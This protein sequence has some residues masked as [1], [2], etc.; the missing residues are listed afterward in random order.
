MIVG[1][2]SSNI[3]KHDRVP[4]SPLRRFVVYVSD[5]VKQFEEE[6]LLT[7]LGIFHC[8]GPTNGL[9][10]KLVGRLTDNV[11]Y[12]SVTDIVKSNFPPHPEACCSPPHHLCGLVF[13][14]IIS[15]VN[16]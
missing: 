6:F 8:F 7:N 14:L 11:K 4:V 3:S 12:S 10:Q 5:I 9:I 2:F 16:I 15:G 1:L 13:N